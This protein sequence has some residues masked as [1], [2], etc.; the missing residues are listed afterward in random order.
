MTELASQIFDQY[1]RD[2]DQALQQGLGVT[3]H[4]REYFAAGR[5]S[6]LARLLEQ[7]DPAQPIDSVLDFG[8]GAGTSIPLLQAAFRP[9]HLLG[10]DPSKQSIEAARV[11]HSDTGAGFAVLDEYRPAGDFALCYT[12]GV[13]HHI[14]PEDRPE[15]AELVFASLA[16]G[17]YFGFFENNPWNPG[18]RYVMRRIPFDRHAKT[19]TPPSAR[20]LLRAAGFQVVA[21]RFLFV[22]PAWLRRL[23]PLEQRL[24]RYPIGAQYLILARRPR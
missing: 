11:G 7:L 14:A 24:D 20:A 10:V 6:Y 5:I 23:Q 21:T 16:P 9:A 18:T 3:G 1:V 17:G 8:C 2:Y 4:G 15:E 19:L 12:N 22:F 13:F